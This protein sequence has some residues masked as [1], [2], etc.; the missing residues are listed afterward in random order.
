MEIHQ[1]KRNLGLRSSFLPSASCNPLGPPVFIIRD[2]EVIQISF[3][4]IEPPI[5]FPYLIFFLS[6]SDIAQ[7]CFAD[8][9]GLCGGASHR[10]GAS[11]WFMCTVC[12]FV[13]Y[14]LV[15]CVCLFVY[16]LFVVCI[17]LF[18]YHSCMFVCLFVY[19]LR[20]LAPFCG[21]ICLLFVY[22][23]MNVYRFISI[24]I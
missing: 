15:V 1:K 7:I 3:P 24:S 17:C 6:A 12:L 2:K 22:S 20:L 18:V 4:S 13:Y 19:W 16:Y 11:L 5:V 9:I 14:L 23:Y 8:K 10:R 21:L